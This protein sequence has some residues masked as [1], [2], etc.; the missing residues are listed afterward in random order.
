M[1]TRV[2]A[3][4]PSTVVFTLKYAYAPFLQR[5]TRGVLVVSHDGPAVPLGRPGH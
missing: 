2:S 5:L 4:G 1:L 3:P